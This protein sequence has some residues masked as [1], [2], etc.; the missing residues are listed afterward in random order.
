[1]KAYGVI[2]KVDELGRIVLPAGLRRKF[3]IHVG[4]CLEIFT[5]GD[6][7]VLKKYEFNDVFTGETEE[8]VDY[9][10][11]KVSKQSIRELMKL[12]DE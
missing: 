4:E 9:K 7:I 5:E 11:K 6:A 2:R 12:L 3:G 10:G 8:L 1:M